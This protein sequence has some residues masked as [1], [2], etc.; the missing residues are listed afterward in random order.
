MDYQYTKHYSVE[1]AR[2][3][4]PSLRNWFEEIDALTDRIRELDELLAPRTKQGEDLGG[5][6]PNQMIRDMA[7]AH[8]ILG[9]FHDRQIQIN[10]LQKGLVDIPALLDER[11][12][13]LCWERT[14]PD[15]THWHTLETGYAD[16]KPLWG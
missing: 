15:I 9:N 2:G 7:R 8:A 16:R 13:F 14:E 1:E 12:V 6:A 4:L 3:L 11:E 5:T 10:D